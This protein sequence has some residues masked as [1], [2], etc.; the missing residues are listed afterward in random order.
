[1]KDWGSATGDNDVTE[2]SHW[3]KDVKSETENGE[4]LGKLLFL[5][6]N[7]KKKELRYIFNF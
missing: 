5:M 2:D 6:Y 3:E 4:H 7:K 1:M